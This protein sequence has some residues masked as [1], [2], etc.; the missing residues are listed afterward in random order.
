MLVKSQLEL[1]LDFWGVRHMAAGDALCELLDTC[2]PHW[3]FK[4]E[5]AS[6]VP[7][8]HSRL[9]LNGNEVLYLWREETI[10]ENHERCQSA[11]F[12]QVGTLLDGG[13]LA[14]P[15]TQS[16]FIGIGSFSVELCGR[17]NWTRLRRKD[18]RTFPFSYQQYL[19][20][21]VSTPDLRYLCS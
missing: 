3:P 20:E 9:C 11:E 14:I 2:F 17:N 6:A 10:V 15:T 7:A 8:E 16:K 5:L 19:L 21:V 13:T 1:A 4:D 18:F 12:L